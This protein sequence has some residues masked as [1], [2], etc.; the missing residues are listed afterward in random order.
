VDASV[1]LHQVIDDPSPGRDLDETGE[2][3]TLESAIQEPEE[4]SVTGVPLV[5]Q[6]DWR[7]IAKQCDALIK[8][9]KDLR[10]AV[11]RTRAALKTKGLIGLF[12]SLRFN[13]ELVARYW[14]DLY[15]RLDEEDSDPTMRINVLK[16]LCNEHMLAELRSAEI[17][18]VR[19]LG[20]YSLHDVLVSKG[21]AKPRANADVPASQHVSQVLRDGCSNEFRALLQGALDSLDG[22]EAEV[23]GQVGPAY[24]CDLS[25]L[26]DLLR[27]M[28]DAI[29]ESAPAATAA[30]GDAHRATSGAEHSASFPEVAMASHEIGSR[31]DVLRTL[32][33]L[34]L[35]YERVEPSSPVPVL[36]ERA[37]RLVPMRFV[38][39]IKDM[40]DVGLP[41]IEVISGQKL[42]PE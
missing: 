22:I 38:D 10:V 36:L 4:P 19:G 28:R 12:D 11:M 39:I 21:L 13:R 24:P 34:L 7:D 23:R 2:L 25:P 40:A 17:A 9:S 29:D 18:S 41:Q 8:Q 31:D 33:R 35:Y 6:R 15:P 14:A 42:T 37:K 5:D 26:G 20:S 30:S 16:E 1:A 3:L 27:R 32:D